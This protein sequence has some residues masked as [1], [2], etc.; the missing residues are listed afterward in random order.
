MNLR[1]IALV[2]VSLS[3]ATACGGKKDG[4][5]DQNKLLDDL[6]KCNDE[7]DRAKNAADACTKQFAEYKSLTPTGPQEILVRIDGEGLTIVGKLGSG[8]PG[9]SQVGAGDLSEA[10]KNV[11]PLV[12]AQIAGSRQAIQQCYVQAL[13]TNTSL[14]GRA[15]NLT[16]QVK[17]SPTGGIGNAEFSPQ[18]SPQFDTCMSTVASRWKIAP[19]QG[20]AFPLQYPLKLQP[21]N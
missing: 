4:G 16:V 19:Y 3:V 15:V 7:R 18:L 11:V 17:V 6:A 20:R 12:I 14:E 10:E 2:V 8:K 1:A 9:E 13:K 5:A 21:V